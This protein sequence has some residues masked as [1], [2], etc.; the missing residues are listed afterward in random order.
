MSGL[1]FRISIGKM[2]SV[3][4]GAAAFVG[5][6]FAGTGVSQAAYFTPS[7]AQLQSMTQAT[8][9][10]IGEGS[11]PGVTAVVTNNG[12][13]IDVTVS[14]DASVTGAGQNGWIAL[15]N[16]TTGAI[17]LTG[18]DGN[19]VAVS[20][21]TGPGMSVRMIQKDLTNFTFYQ[22]ADSTTNLG[23]TNP[24]SGFVTSTFNN[25]TPTAAFDIANMFE[26]SLRFRF[27]ALPTVNTTATFT[28]TPAPEPASVALLALALPAAA[29]RRRRIPI[30]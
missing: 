12:A 7:T 25:P 24:S 20:L 14:F 5:L 15:S 11:S 18:F 22:S 1:P 26:I 19:Q 3:V 16:G 2:R 13:G 10:A 17:N 4:V 28:I 30:A 9:T 29:L 6:G 23:G 8:A 21:N 27:A